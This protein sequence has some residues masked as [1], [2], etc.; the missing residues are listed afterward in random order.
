MPIELLFLAN[1]GPY[2]RHARI[3]ST[4]LPCTS[5]SRRSMPLWRNVSR[6]GRCP[7]GAGWWRAG[8]SSRSG[9]RRPASP[10][11]RSRREP[12]PPLTPAP[13]SQATD[14]PPLWSRP[15]A[16]WVNGC[17]PNSVLQMTSVSSSRPRAFRSRSRPAI[18]P[19]DRPGD[20]GQLVGDVGVVVPVVRRPAGAAPDLDEPDAALEQPAGEQAA[21][22]EVGGGRVVEAVEACGRRRLAGQVEGLGRRLLHP[23]RQLVGGDPRFEPRVALVERGVAAVHPG[24]LLQ[25]V[26][27]AGRRDEACRRGAKRSGIGRGAA[28]LMIVPWCDI[29]RKPDVKLPLAL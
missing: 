12:T 23:R 11:G 9:R 10:R 21:P 5:V 7:A 13:A 2:R 4:T 14:V 8:R 3:A 28:A 24:E 6:C 1:W 17:R 29:G 15:V 16:P 22:A 18:G 19:I 27:L 25:A 26:A 20:R